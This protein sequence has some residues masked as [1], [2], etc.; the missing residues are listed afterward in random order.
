MPARPGC[1]P[2]RGF[3]ERQAASLLDVLERAQRSEQLSAGWGLMQSLDPRV[4]LLS[5][6]AVIAVTVGTRNPWVLGALFALCLGTAFLSRI[7]L[8]LFWR[9]VWLNVLLFSGVLILPAIFLVPGEVLFRLPGLGFPISR[10]GAESALMLLGRA[11]TAS[12][13]AALTLLSTPWAQLLKALRTLG[14]PAV[15]VAILGMTYRYLFVVLQMSMD[16]LTSRRSRQVGH[17]CAAHRRRMLVADA[18]VLLA[19][20]MQSAEGA[21]L[22]MQSRGYRGGHR[23]LTEFRLTFRDGLALLFFLL[24]AVLIYRHG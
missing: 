2:G 18:G 23:L 21:Y 11:F 13:A 17:L 4:R 9:G 1:P 12:T 10:P 16:M 8:R 19:K 7:P 6:L 15:A 5:M 3:L 14:L 24:V 22:A 20:S